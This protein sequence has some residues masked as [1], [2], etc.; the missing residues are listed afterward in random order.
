MKLETIKRGGKTFVLVEQGDYERL[1][2]ARANAQAKLP[3]LPAPDADGNV[4]A[5]EFARASIARDIVSRRLA[6][7]MTQAD[8]ARAAGV[9]AETLNRLENARHTAD[10]ATLTKIDAA[11]SAAQTPRR[12]STSD[13]TRGTTTP[14]GRRVN[15]RGSFTFDSLNARAGRERSR[16]A[17]QAA[18]S[19]RASQSTRKKSAK[20]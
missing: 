9:R 3:P 10:V 18:R 6:A 19:E 20:K 1:T 12:P 2:G 11:L 5:V 15:A 17:P 13:R 14:E 4:D 16:P 7:G 8:L